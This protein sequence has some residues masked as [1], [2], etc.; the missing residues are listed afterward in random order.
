MGSVPTVND[1]PNNPK[2]GDMWNI[3]A[4][5]SNYVWS[6]LENR[7]DKVG[8]GTIDLSNYYTKTQCDNKFLTEHQ[9][10]SNYYTKTQCDN[11]F[12]TSH[13]SLSNYYTK[14]E[15]DSTFVTEAQILDLIDQ[16]DAEIP[17]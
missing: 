1:L 7:W 2:N 6:D 11:K 12:L 3:T 10:L 13:Q 9:S 14:S 4:D 5:D 16:L 8:G 17:S 15:C